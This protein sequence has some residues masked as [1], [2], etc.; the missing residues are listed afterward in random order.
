MMKQITPYE[1]IP[2]NKIPGLPRPPRPPAPPKPPKPMTPEQY[3]KQARPLLGQPFS[4]F[5]PG[6]PFRGLGR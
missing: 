1:Q 5:N 2:F 4:P 3:F 6:A